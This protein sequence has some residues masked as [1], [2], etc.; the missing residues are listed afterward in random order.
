VPVLPIESSVTLPVTDTLQDDVITL[1]WDGDL[2]DTSTQVTVSAAQA[3]KP[4]QI[5]IQKRFVSDNLNR[6]VRI[7]YDLARANV[8]RRF[9]LIR[10]LLIRP[11]FDHITNFRNSN[12]NGW[13]FGSALTDMRDR[14]FVNW[15]TYTTFYNYTY[16]ENNKTGVIFSQTF[17]NLR[18]GSAYI[19]SIQVRRFDGR[20][21]LPFIGLRSSQSQ[22]V[23]ATQISNMGSWRTLSGSV[24]PSGSSIT[25]YIDSHQ[26]SAQGND[27]EIGEIRF[28][29]A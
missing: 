17:G 20:F 22:V 8:P 16:G 6:S 14:R 25:L 10:V 18:P 4:L 12:Q 2:S 3:G 9:S 1:I 13:A 5:S 19:F 7:R 21:T 15:G 28:R 27:Y 23:S 24:T 29:L 26:A 11:G